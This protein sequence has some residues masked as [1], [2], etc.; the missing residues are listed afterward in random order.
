VTDPFLVSAWND[1]GEAIVVVT[2]AAVAEFLAL[3]R[4]DR[5]LL[6]SLLVVNMS[7]NDNTIVL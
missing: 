3:D 1:D 4:P 6:D 2:V 7:N 5:L